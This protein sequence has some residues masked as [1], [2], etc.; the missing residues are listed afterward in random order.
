MGSVREDVPNPLKTGGPREFKGLVG[1]VVGSGDI[2]VETVGGEE[3]W[4]VEGS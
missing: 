3:V 2:F 1:W 4:D